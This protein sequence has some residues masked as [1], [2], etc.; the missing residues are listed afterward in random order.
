MK[1][2]M[3]FLMALLIL[4][5]LSSS[6]Q[7]SQDRLSEEVKEEIKNATVHIKNT[8]GGGGSRLLYNPLTRL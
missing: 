3:K 7:T 4:G 8:S 5:F 1:Q 6:A 2:N